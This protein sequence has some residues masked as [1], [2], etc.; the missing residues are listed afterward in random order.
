MS[1]PQ[2]EGRGSGK[3]RDRGKLNLRKLILSTTNYGK[4]K[5]REKKKGEKKKKEK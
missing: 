4:R 5:K 1:T 3:H 2:W